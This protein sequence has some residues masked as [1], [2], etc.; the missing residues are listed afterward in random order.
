MTMCP[1][2]SVQTTTKY[3]ICSILWNKTLPS[4][5]RTSQHLSCNYRSDHFKTETNHQ[6]KAENTCFDLSVTMWTWVKALLSVHRNVLDK[7]YDNQ[8]LLIIKSTICLLRPLNIGQRI[9]VK[10]LISFQ[11][12]P[13]A[14]KTFA[15]NVQSSDT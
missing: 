14:A 1:F 4:Q 5:P 11:G 7:N 13:T 9:I 12:H 10:A 2:N 8:L 6:I 15:S 3:K